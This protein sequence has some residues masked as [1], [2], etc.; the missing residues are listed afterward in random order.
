LR[1]H[2]AQK[3]EALQV[4]RPLGTVVTLVG[5]A[6][7]PVEQ[8][9]IDEPHRKVQ[10]RQLPLQQ[11]HPGG[12][13]GRADIGHDSWR[14]QRGA[15]GRQAGQQQARVDPQAGLR[16]RQRAD[17]VGQT[18]GLDVRVNLGR[19]VQH[20]HGRWRVTLGVTRWSGDVPGLFSAARHRRSHRSPP[21]AS[22]A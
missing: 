4:V 1:R 7:A 16:D 10:S 15:Q 13:K 21:A 22:R 5:V 8:G 11:A 9:R 17:N 2:P 19:D 6:G 14:F 3:T 18:A 20:A 12:A